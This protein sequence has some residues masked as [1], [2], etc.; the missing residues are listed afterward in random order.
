MAH[1]GPVHRRQGVYS[2]QHWAPSNY[3]LLRTHFAYLVQDVLVE[4]TLVETYQARR[5][6]DGRAAH[7]VFQVPPGASVVDFG[8]R[9]DGRARVHAR[10][11]DT[12]SS[13]PD[14]APSTAGVQAWKLDPV[15]EKGQTHLSR[16]CPL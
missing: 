5:D 10:V 3:A 12:R 11:D 8:A 13:S 2:E 6:V 1:V 16:A 9:I 15:H 4:G 14:Q 7:Y